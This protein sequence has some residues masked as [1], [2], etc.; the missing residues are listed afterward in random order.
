M[1]L[2]Q[3]NKTAVVIRYIVLIAVAIGMLYPL[4]WLISGIW[5]SN[6]EIFT[7]PLPFTTN[8]MDGWAAIVQ[9]FRTR[10]PGINLGG[11][12]LNSLRFLIPRVITQTLS[13]L[14]TAYAISR[15]RFIGKKI[16]F[17]LVIVTLLMPDVV[18]RIPL[19]LLWRDL[20]MLNTFAPLWLDA[21]FA[22][23]SFFTFMLIQ[24]M[25]TIPRDLDEAAKI[26]GCGSFKILFLIIVPVMK[27]A[28][29]TVAL[30]TFMWGMNDFIGPLIYIND[31]LLQP[32]STGLR[33]ASDTTGSAVQFN[34][35]FAMSAMALIPA[36]TLFFVAQ[37]YFIDGIAAT[38]SKE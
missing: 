12:F 10:I 2:T 24:F 21:A 29:I 16:F 32:L 14:L 18:F 33:L 8:P 5:K 34:E 22:T 28:I 35:I 38:G 31:P 25:R 9:G 4:I 30:L 13:C 6:A 15:F 27:P 11:F 3:K 26:D 23:G 37:R 1:T 36:I 7:S 19:F 17:T 20:G